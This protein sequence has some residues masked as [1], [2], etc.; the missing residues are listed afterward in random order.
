MNKTDLAYMAGF[1]DGEGCVQI[2]R[3][4]VE[5]KQIKYWL[6]ITIV[7]AKE[8]GK[9]ICEW[10]EFNFGGNSFKR[11]REREIYVWK[12]GARKA[13]NFLKQIYFY[14]RIKKKQVELVL[15]FQEKLN[16]NGRKMGSFR[17]KRIHG[18]SDF[19]KIE[20][21]C[22]F[23]TIKQEITFLKGRKIQK[24]NWMK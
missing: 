6:E 17:D 21:F 18:Y 24:V 9:Q 23:E 5:N 10:F 16:K 13:Y 15:E 1:F 2:H 12:I 19:E 14:L 11:K 3:G 20:R 4:F 22:Y 7:Q 8:E